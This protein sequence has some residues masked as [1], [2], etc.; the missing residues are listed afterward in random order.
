MGF[1]KDGP[2]AFENALVVKRGEKEASAQKSS[3][4][5]KQNERV[6]LGPVERKYLV[7]RGGHLTGRMLVAVHWWKC[8][9]GATCV[10][11]GC[12]D[13]TIPAASN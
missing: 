4:S 2:Q 3:P 7:P 1:R 6:E 11:P 10:L 9:R 12:R 5:Y 8:Y 13:C